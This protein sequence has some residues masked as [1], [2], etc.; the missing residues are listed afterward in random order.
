MYN[1]NE[2]GQI[3]VATSAH[4]FNFKYV[5]TTWIDGNLISETEKTWASDKLNDYD[6]FRD[7]WQ[8]LEAF[9]SHYQLTEVGSLLEDG[10]VSMV[11]EY[12]LDTDYNQTVKFIRG[13]S[14]TEA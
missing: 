12:T 2:N 5:E 7:T 8:E 1:K 11:I 3:S 10:N 9:D 4:K 6:R 13:V 14:Y